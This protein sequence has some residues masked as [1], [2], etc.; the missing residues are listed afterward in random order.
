M[1]FPSEWKIMKLMFQSTNQTVSVRNE[2]TRQ[3]WNPYQ[4]IHY[5]IKHHQTW[6]ESP[7]CS[8]IFPIKKHLHLL[9]FPQHW[10]PDNCEILSRVSRDQSHQFPQFGEQPERVSYPEILGKSSWFHDF[11]CSDRVISMLCLQHVFAGELA[12]DRPQVAG[13]QHPS[14]G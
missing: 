7:R 13:C 12:T 11:F 4:G 14:C 9:G 5:I 1:K 8:M 2:N 6:L 3:F 10:V